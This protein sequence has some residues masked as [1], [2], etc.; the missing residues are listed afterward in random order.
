MSSASVVLWSLLQ[1]A[2]YHNQQI[3]LRTNQYFVMLMIA[4]QLLHFEFIF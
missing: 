3:T 1:E 2:D 4:L